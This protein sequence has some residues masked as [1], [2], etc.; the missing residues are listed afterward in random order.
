[1]RAQPGKVRSQARA[2][3]VSYTHLDVYKRQLEAPRPPD[4]RRN[5]GMNP[6]QVF[7]ETKAFGKPLFFAEFAFAGG[8]SPYGIAWNRG[9]RLWENAA[10]ERKRFLPPTFRKTGEARAA[11]DAFLKF[12]MVLYRG[13]KPFRRVGSFRKKMAGN[14][15]SSVCTARHRNIFVWFFMGTKISLKIWGTEWKQKRNGP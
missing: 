5:G 10:N 9:R 14:I 7:G 4:G 12:Y 3:S 6:R 2:I 13:R 1:M 11:T 15:E 8:N